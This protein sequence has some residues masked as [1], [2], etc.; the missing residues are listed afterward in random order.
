[1][2]APPLRHAP[3]RSAMPGAWTSSE[4]AP[5]RSERAVSRGGGGTLV[6]DVDADV[7]GSGLRASSLPQLES[8]TETISPYQ[9]LLIGSVYSRLVASS[10]RFQ[11]DGRYSAWLR[12]WRKCLCG[13]NGAETGC[14]PSIETA[15]SNNEGRAN[16]GTLAQTCAG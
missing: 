5:H 9:C 2:S 12:C 11:N 7:D 16:G 4:T 13:N 8:A 10:Q 1:P 3:K 6:V 14:N 15:R